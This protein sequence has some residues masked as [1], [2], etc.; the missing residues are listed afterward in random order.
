MTVRREPHRKPPVVPAHYSGLWIAW[1]ADQ[2]EIVGSGR[3]LAEAKE[4]ARAKGEME[5]LFAKVPKANVRF[6]GPAR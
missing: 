5:P 2:T 6:V 4:A 3:T 1:N